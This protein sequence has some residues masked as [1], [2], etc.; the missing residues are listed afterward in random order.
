[1]ELEQRNAIVQEALDWI[2][3][4]FI[5]AGRQKGIGCDCAGLVL[6]VYKNVGLLDFEYSE[7]SSYAP[8]GMMRNM[9]LRFCDP[10]QSVLFCLPGDILLFTLYGYEQHIAIATAP[11]AQRMCHAFQTPGVVVEHE[12]N[13]FWLNRITGVFTFVGDRNWQH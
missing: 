12:L 4:R 11:E 6:G 3:T 5:H 7:Y 13:N 8:A 1:M 9:L 2:G 10:L